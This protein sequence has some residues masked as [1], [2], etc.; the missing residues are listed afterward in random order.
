[1]F[2]K[3]KCLGREPFFLRIFLGLEEFQ[4][5]LAYGFYP[6]FKGIWDCG[7]VSDNMDVKTTREP[8]F[9]HFEGALFSFAIASEFQEL[10]KGSVYIDVT[11]LYIEFLKPSHL[12]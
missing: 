7:R 12:L 9:E 5:L 1:M 11:I 2:G 8:C 10:L 3:H 4:L 6:A